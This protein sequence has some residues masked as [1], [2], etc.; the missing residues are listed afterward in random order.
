MP[1]DTT[2]TQEI[3]R[4]QQEMIEA[5]LGWTDAAKTAIM[6]D[7]YEIIYFISLDKEFAR[8]KID[9]AV[10]NGTR[11]DYLPE[12]IAERLAT[13]YFAYVDELSEALEY[14]NRREIH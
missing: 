14:T 12:D 10:Y 7:G 1:G 11:F 2:E 4:M 8:Q 13:I 3:I 6:C 9:V 5:H